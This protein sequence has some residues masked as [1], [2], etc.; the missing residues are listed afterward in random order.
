M[1]KVI[2]NTSPLLYLYRIDALTW[3]PELF[4]SIWTPKSVVDELYEGQQRGYDVPI[5]DRYS[6]LQVIEFYSIGEQL[7]G[8]DLGN[9][10]QAAIA[11][12]LEH[13]DRI[14]LWFGEACCSIAWVYRLGNIKDFTG[15]KIS[16][17]TR[18]HCSFS[19]S[20]TKFRHVDV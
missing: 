4:D 3:L 5:P 19:R 13:P 14:V 15:G 6:W 11:L 17:V 20:L 10:E 16:R 8:L 9:G 18:S 2:S 12:G 7:K 1:S